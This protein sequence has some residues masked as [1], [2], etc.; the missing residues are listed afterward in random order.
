MS[1]CDE[2]DETKVPEFIVTFE[3]NGGSAVKAKTVKEGKKVA[4]PADPTREGYAFAAWFKEEALT[5]EWGFATDVVTADIT[6]YAK[7]DVDENDNDVVKLLESITWDDGSKYEYEYDIQNRITIITE[8]DATETFTYSG[9]DLIKIVRDGDGYTKTTDFIKN[10]NKITMTVTRSDG[11]NSTGT[12]D[13]DNDGFPTKCIETFEEHNYYSVYTF[14]IQ[15]GNLTESS[16][17]EIEIGENEEPRN[18]YKYKYDNKISPFHHCKTPNWYMFFYMIDVE[19]I[20]GSQNNVTEYM[21]EIDDDK[22]KTEFIY[23]YDSTGF[24]TKCTVEYSGGGKSVIM[25]T[26]K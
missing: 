18:I 26:Y 7:W 19:V 11:F 6:L 20:Y 13:L 5:T 25:Y 24:P 14:K 21:F 8:N 12:I 22:L 4:K 1:S 23:E 17:N 16:Y 9:E 10:E 2:D 3:S 15:D